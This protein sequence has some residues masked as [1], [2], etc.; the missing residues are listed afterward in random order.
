MDGMTTIK[1][2][3]GMLE[4]GEN[5]SYVKQGDG[6]I[7]CMLGEIGEN[8]DKHPY[9]KDLG[10]ELISAYAYLNTLPNSYLP[11]WTDFPMPNP[12]P[13]KGNVDGN[14]FLHGS[15]NQE[16][17]DFFKALK[18][19]NRKKVYVGPEKS[20]VVIP[21]LNIDEY[22]EVPLVNSWSF[23]FQIEPEDNVVYLFAAGMPGKAWMA[24]LLRK[25]RNITCIDIGSG[26]DPIFYPP[27][28][29]RQLSMG[30]LREFYKELL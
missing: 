21:F 29:T 9:A 6:E 10:E 22:V 19:L 20:R 7:L 3:Q 26:L 4:R 16:K 14:T 25:N 5:F 8:L 18:F 24:R 11:G 12:S 17:F 1:D 15:V 23:D 27:N 13:V 2:F 28:R 30:V